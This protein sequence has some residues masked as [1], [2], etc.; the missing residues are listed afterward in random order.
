[1]WS[2]HRGYRECIFSQI[3]QTVVSVGGQFTECSLQMSRE[4]MS[5]IHHVTPIE[6]QT[7][8]QTYLGKLFLSLTQYIREPTGAYCPF[9]ISVSK[10]MGNMQTHSVDSAFIQLLWWENSLKLTI[11][12]GA[13][14]T[15]TQKLT[16]VQS[17]F[18]HTRCPLLIS[19]YTPNLMVT[20]ISTAEL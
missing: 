7:W 10:P 13:T 12:G 11:S 14:W 19:N 1:M 9:F 20:A 2:K 17:P 4:H 15:G 18:L 5:L 8:S 6:G 16:V 3:K